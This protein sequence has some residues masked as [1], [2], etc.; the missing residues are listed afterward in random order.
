MVSGILLP[1]LLEVI[2]LVLSVCMC[3]CLSVYS[4]ICLC[5]VGSIAGPMDLEFGTHIKNHHISNKSEG[6][7]H[8]SKVKV[9]NWKCKNLN[10]Q[11]SWKCCQCTR[12][13]GH[14]VQ[15][16]RPRLKFLSP[17][18]THGNSET[19]AFSFV[20]CSTDTTVRVTEPGVVVSCGYD[21]CLRSRLV[22]N[23]TTSHFPLIVL[24]YP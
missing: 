4:S 6:Q 16:Q 7:G 15:D 14:R 19:Q 21:T 3:L 9:T 5:Y 24:G 13:Y 22:M 2:F 23:Y 10:F 1:P 20:M 8:G 17:S 11:P 12:G 18:L